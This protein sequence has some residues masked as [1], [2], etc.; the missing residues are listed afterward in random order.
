MTLPADLLHLARKHRML[1]LRV[2]HSY[3]ESI[4]VRTREQAEEMRRDGVEFE[5]VSNDQNKKD[6]S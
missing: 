2:C 5:I 6:K 3:G 4:V 1:V